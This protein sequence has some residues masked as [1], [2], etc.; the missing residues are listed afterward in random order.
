MGSEP[1]LLLNRKIHLPHHT[2]KDR[3]A[4]LPRPASLEGAPGFGELGRW[5]ILAAF[6]RLVFQAVDNRWGIGGE[7]G[8]KLT[9]RNQTGV[10]SLDQLARLCQA[11]NLN[12][13]DEPKRHQDSSDLPPFRGGLIGFVGYD[14]AP[15]LEELPR[16]IERKSLIPDI[17]FALHDT[18][19]TIDHVTGETRI[20]SADLL[21]EGP[22]A[23]RRRLDRFE[24]RLL[25][26]PPREPRPTILETP[27][28]ANFSRAEY[29]S[30]VAHAL[31]YIRAGD[32]FQVNISQRFLA[33][34]RNVDPRDLHRR[35][36]LKS[37]VPMGAFLTHG[38]WAVLSASPE[39]FYQ[40]RGREILTRPIKGTRPRHADRT[41]DQQLALDLAASPKDRAELTM[42]VDLERNDLGRLCEYGTVQVTDPLTIESY[43][44]VH[45][46]VAT[47]QG[48]LRPGVNAVEIM[49]AMMPGGSIT[50]APKI[51]AMQIIDEL[52]R[53]RRSLY[54]GAIGYLSR[55]GDSAFNIAIRTLLVE[56]RQLS[57]Q[58]G[59]GIVVDSEPGNEFEETLHKG[60]GLFEVLSRRETPP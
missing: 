53:S 25:Q 24:R 59:G 42:I 51:R 30:A 43:A 54:T 46:M 47:V 8:L 23:T 12:P 28:T 35:L 15:Q 31:E 7:P 21:S 48:R 20:W 57:Y 44:Q 55:G 17:H 39:L 34:A 32:I 16:R 45:H 36:R 6:P 22:A 33:K 58:V 9:S 26:K 60:Q 29:E 50:G 13:Q 49:R 38:R 27:I 5:S 3:V 10:G 56:G 18:V 52:E 40:T 2:L 19:A 1:G 41:K 37:P 4:A 14:I 11:L